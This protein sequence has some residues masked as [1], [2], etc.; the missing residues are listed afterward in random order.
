MSFSS[1]RFSRTVASMLLIGS[2][3]AASGAAA[4]DQPDTA[5]PQQ[6]QTAAEKSQQTPAVDASGAA[7]VRAPA[8][9]RQRGGRDG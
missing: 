7:T 1:F 5:N 4:M 8:S 2:L 6:R 9:H 3:A